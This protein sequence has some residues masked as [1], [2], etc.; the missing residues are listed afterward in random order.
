MLWTTAAPAS[1][2]P[3]PVHAASQWLEPKT[4]VD[5]NIDVGGATLRLLLHRLLVVWRVQVPQGTHRS[6]P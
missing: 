2:H 4:A 5:P 3:G 6:L 1:F